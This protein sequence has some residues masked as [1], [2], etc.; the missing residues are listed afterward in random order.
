MRGY[1]RLRKAAVTTLGRR[2]ER[3]CRRPK[4]PHVD[5]RLFGRTYD[6]GGV[7]WEIEWCGY[8]SP[9]SLEEAILRVCPALR[10]EVESYTRATEKGR[11]LRILADETGPRP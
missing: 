7:R 3:P 9:Y 1:R 8:C 10:R 5:F 11:E 6:E 2:V 4:G